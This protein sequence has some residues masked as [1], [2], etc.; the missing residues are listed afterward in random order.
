MTAAF[1][2][3]GA[4]PSLCVVAS[5]QVMDVY[6]DP[7]YAETLQLTRAGAS[8]DS[9]LKHHLRTIGSGDYFAILAY[10]ERTQTNSDALQRVRLSLRDKYRVATSIGF[11]PRFLHSTGQAHKGGPNTGVFLQVTANDEFDFSAPS[12]LAPS[13]L[14]PSH[15]A[16][17][18][19][20][21]SHS[22]TF[23]VLKTSQARADFDVLSSRGR[24]TLGVHLKG[25]IASGLTALSKAVERAI[26]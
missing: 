7:G 17:S 11:G 18:L 20:A 8:V 10:I 23:G 12:R 4:L 22:A 21:S 5:N 24:R 6:A 13:H 26:S 15:S 3:T 16:P 9:C 1:E 19:A 14:A 25:E 2:K